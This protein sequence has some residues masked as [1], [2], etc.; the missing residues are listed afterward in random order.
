[1]S[2]PSF[3]LT[4]ILLKKRGRTI[5]VAVRVAALFLET[6]LFRHGDLGASHAISACRA[7]E[8]IE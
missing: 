2:N 7:G 8:T 5:A 4:G 3:V 1:M 6:V